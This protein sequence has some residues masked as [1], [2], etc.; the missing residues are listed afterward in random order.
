VHGVL[1]PVLS[2]HHASLL[3]APA[4]NEWCVL[5]ADQFTATELSSLDATRRVAEVYVDGAVIPPSRRLGDV[6]RA[7][8]R[9]LAA[10]VFGAECI[11]VAQWCVETASE[12]AKVREQ[13]GRPV[14]QFQGVKHKCADMLAD[15][16]LARAAVWDGARA[17]AEPAVAPLTA[18]AAASL[19][20][21]A[22]YR[23]A[24][25]C[26]QVHGGIGFTWEHD[27]HLYFKRATTNRLLLG[28][29]TYHYERALRLDPEAKR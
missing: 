26:I 25:D 8:V 20:V 14:G 15:T 10:V 13:F 22:S 21:D 16:E 4:G 24:K 2:G 23:V 1:R 19:A 9:D 12:Y 17:A 18:A 27:A 7:Q 28:D 6:E 3:V 5:D 29:A 11:G